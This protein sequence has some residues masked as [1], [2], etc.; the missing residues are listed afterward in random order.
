M[1]PIT[2][3]NE[4][5]AAIETCAAAIAERS[6]LDHLAAKVLA[7]KSTATAAKGK[8]E[9]RLEEIEADLELSMARA[10]AAVAAGERAS[11]QAAAKAAK[12]EIDGIRRELTELDATI[13]K[14]ERIARA[15]PERQRQADDVIEPAI[16][17]LREAVAPFLSDMAALY[18]ADITAA[19]EG[20]AKTLGRWQVVAHALRDGR[21][22]M[23]VRDVKIPAVVPRTAALLDDGLFLKSGDRVALPSLAPDLASEFEPLRKILMVIDPLT[24][25]IS[26]DRERA[27]L[28]A[29]ETAR[30]ASPDVRYST[31]AVP[32]SLPPAP[33]PKFVNTAKNHRSPGVPIE[34]NIALAGRPNFAGE[35][36]LEEQL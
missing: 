32:P 11:D 27:R 5:T 14:S 16:T 28:A 35:R 20:L 6:A 36:P 13:L 30:A 10:E 18:Q 22:L 34:A 1:K 15:L 23:H 25:R 29:N 7:E 9:R 26:D 19:A 31:P 2:I 8:A 33:A 17:A 24:R 3:P 21:M 12:K 4:L